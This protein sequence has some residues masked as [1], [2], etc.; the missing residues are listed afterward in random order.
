MKLTANHIRVYVRSMPRMSEGEQRRICEAWIEAS[1]IKSHVVYVEGASGRD[2]WLR[3]LRDDEVACVA[4]LDVLAKPRAAG[5]RPSA[6]F[7]TTLAAITARCAFIVDASAE[8]TSRDGKR[9]LDVV[10]WAANH[11]AKGR[12]TLTRKQAQKMARARKKSPPG[13]VEH[14][15]SPGMAKQLARWGAIWRDVTKYPNQDAAFAAMDQAVQDE[16]NSPWTARKVFGP[17][18]PGDKTAGGRP[19]GK[20]KR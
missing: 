4:R 15:H 7:T 10:E 8:V 1:G 19:K 20:G 18:R 16:I 13:V 2:A 5:V 9:W 6:D 14:W 17:R 11:I 3:A 12:R